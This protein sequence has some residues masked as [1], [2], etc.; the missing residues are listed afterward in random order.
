MHA[1]AE[2]HTIDLWANFATDNPAQ[3]GFL[4]SPAKYRLLS[5]GRGGGLRQC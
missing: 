1:V 5:S 3:M 2:T 4:K